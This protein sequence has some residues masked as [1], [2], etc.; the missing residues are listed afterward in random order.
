LCE[1]NGRADPSDDP[2]QQDRQDPKIIF[3]AAEHAQGPFGALV[4][5]T[6][7]PALEKLLPKSR[8]LWPRN[9]TTTAVSQIGNLPSAGGSDTGF[10]GSSRFFATLDAVEEIFYVVNRSVPIAVFGKNRVVVPGHPFTMYGESAAV[11]FQRGVGTAE[12][13]PAIVD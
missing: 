1:R 4:W 3:H 6:I 13:Q 10:H 12:F 5:H 11:E 2:G 8:L 7:S 9:L